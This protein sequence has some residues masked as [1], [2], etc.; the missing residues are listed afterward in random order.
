[1]LKFS[2]LE[3]EKNE[4]GQYNMQEMCNE[5]VEEEPF[6]MQL[7]ADH[8]MLEFGHLFQD[9]KKETGYYKK[10]EMFNED[11]SSFLISLKHKK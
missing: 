2:C 6:S 7:L 10:Q 1:M 3:E 5:T 8:L 4:I 11:T 9:E